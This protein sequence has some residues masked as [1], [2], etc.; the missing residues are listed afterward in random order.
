MFNSLVANL[1]YCMAVTQ[2]A[3]AAVEPGFNTPL[4]QTAQAAPVTT[5]A[6]PAPTELERRT[7]EALQRPTERNEQTDHRVAAFWFVRTN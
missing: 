7:A 6:Q 3:G 1:V 4:P 2:S 5:E